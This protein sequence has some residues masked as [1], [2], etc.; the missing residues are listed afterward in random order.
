MLPW[1]YLRIHV[2]FQ[3][4]TEYICGG[5]P[6]LIVTL[7]ELVHICVAPIP[8][9]PQVQALQHSEKGSLSL[10]YWQL[11]TQEI[12]ELQKAIQQGEKI[13][14]V[15]DDIFCGENF[16]DLAELLEL[17]SDDMTIIFSFDDAQLYQNKKSD[18]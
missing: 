12:L 15:D 5:L 10:Q 18:T 2:Q 17:S 7:S 3:N 14:F 9:G 1:A 6:V 13:E 4:F 8:P 16:L 11:Q